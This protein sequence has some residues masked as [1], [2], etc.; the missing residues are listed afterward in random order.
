MKSH[1]AAAAVAGLSA[2]LLLGCIAMAVAHAGVTVPLLSRFGP[3]GSDP[4]WPA[5][6]AFSIGALLMAT[7]VIGTL[8]RRPWSW[9]LG[10]VVHGLVIFG[11][12]TPYRGVGSLVAI[13]LAGLALALLVSRPG[14]AAL[15]PAQP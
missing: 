9:A 12:V 3:G 7:L 10:V 13:V 6:I 11:S 2:V 8:R 15:L 4:V 14:R 1:P 5:F